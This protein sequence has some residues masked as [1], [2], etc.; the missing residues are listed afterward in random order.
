MKFCFEKKIVYLFQLIWSVVKTTDLVFSTRF[1]TPCYKVKKETRI[2]FFLIFIK[3][4]LNMSISFSP[5]TIS[6]QP[7]KNLERIQDSIRIKFTL[8]IHL[9]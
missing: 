2:E 4:L 7:L 9:L 1:I 6:I 5:V 3:I 8:L